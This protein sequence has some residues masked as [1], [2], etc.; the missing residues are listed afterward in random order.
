MNRNQ[1]LSQLKEA[2]EALDEM[3]KSIESTADYDYGDYW[4]DMQ[5]VYHHLNTA[6]NS[7]DES[8]ERISKATDVDFN[9][10]SALPNDLPMMEVRA[11]A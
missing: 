4:V 7:R 10:W 9:R 2:S 6:W 11:T 3:I 1:V 8:E 5:H